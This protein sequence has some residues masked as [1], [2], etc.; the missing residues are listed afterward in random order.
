MATATLQAAAAAQPKGPSN[1]RSLIIDAVLAVG[2]FTI[3]LVYR[4]HFPTDGLFYDDAWQAFGAAEGRLAAVLHDRPD[5]ARVRIRT[6]G[7]ERACSATA[8]P[9]WSSRR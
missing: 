6:D 4:L 5:A 2:L 3:A 9:R 8:R 7:V 1:H